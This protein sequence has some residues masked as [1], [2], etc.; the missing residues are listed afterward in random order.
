MKIYTYYEN[1]N[2]NEQNELLELWK[3]SWKSKGFEPIVLGI[4]D[5]KK[6]EDYDSFCKK[7]KLIYKKV[8]QKELKPYGLSCFV[9]WLAYSTVEDKESR[10]LVSDYDVINSGKWKTWHPITNKLHFYDADCPCLASGTPKEFKELCNAFFEVTM[11]RIGI[12]KKKADHYHDQEFFTYNCMEQNNSEVEEL[13]IKY[14]MFF[15]RRRCEDV[16][17]FGTNCDEKVRAFHISH[18]NTHVI[19]DMYPEKYKNL[20]DDKVRIEIVKEILKSQ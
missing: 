13:W 12:L 15:S 4:E 17:P 14:N 10:F 7:M 2:F 9:R 1:I 5:A 18:H 19:K 20:A 6:S 11:K 8:T 16:A 3:A